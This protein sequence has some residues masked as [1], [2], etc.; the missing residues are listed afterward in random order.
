MTTQAGYE[1]LYIGAQWVDPIDGEIHDSIDPSTGKVWTR[2]AFAGAKDVDRAVVAAQEAF[3]GGWG[4][5]TPTQ[6]AEALRRIAAR[7]DEQA[8]RLAEIESRDNGL[9][10]RDALGMVKAAV[11]QFYYFAGLADKLEGRNIP[12]D[13]NVLAYTT[14]IPV[15]VVGAILAWNVPMTLLSW[16]LAPALAAG[17]TV[18]IKSAEQT[19]ASAYEF[20]R[21]IEDLGLPPGVINIISG[22]GA[23]A[24]HSLVAHPGVAKISFTGEHR[25]AQ[26]IMQTGAVNLKRFTFECGGKSAHIIFDDA[27]LPQAI[28]AATFN[29]FAVCGQSCA[30]GS[31]VLVHRSIHD[32]VAEEFARRAKAVRVGPSSDPASQM[33]PQAHQEQLEKTLRYIDIAREEGAQMLAGGN[34]LTEGVLAGGYFVEPTVLAGVNNRMRVAREEIFGPVVSLIPF[35]SEEEA[36]EIANDTEYGLTAG[37]WTQDV[38]RAHRVSSRLNVGVVWVNT[39][40]FGHWAIPYGGVKISGYG[41][42]NGIEALDY[43]LQT[44]ATVINLTSQYPDRFA[45]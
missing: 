1:K 41:R 26:V 36:L 21:V 43:F 3:N 14:R 18:V 17:C 19:P 38:G 45:N 27:D 24:G 11:Q 28:N 33:G 37:L 23:V 7:I 15:G 8:E 40:R 42:E 34:R 32:R 10:F 22:H 44:K 31:R 6:R 2:A 13:S 5:Y 9:L 39:Y 29:A 35:D 25:T 20:A 30:L 12:V 16:K 4:A